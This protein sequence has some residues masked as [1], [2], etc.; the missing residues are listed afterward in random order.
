MLTGKATLAGTTAACTL[1]KTG[2]TNPCPATAWP[3]AGS[4]DIGD[5]ITIKVTTPFNS[6]IAMF[7]PGAKGMRFNAATLGAQSSDRIQY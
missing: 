7:W 1:D 3:P 5:V 6:A 2:G 4:N